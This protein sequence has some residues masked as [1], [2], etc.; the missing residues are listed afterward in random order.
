MRLVPFVVVLASGLVFAQPAPDAGTQVYSKVVRSTVWIHSRHGQAQATGSGSLIDR[1]RSLVLTNYHVVGDEDRATV[2]FPAYRDGKLVAERSEYQRRLGEIGIKGR[3][4]ARDPEHDLAVIQIDTVPAGVSAL[5]LVDK[6]VSTGQS[7]HSIGNPGGS[8]ALWVYTPGRVRQVYKKQW[9]AKLDNRIANFS[10]EVV[11]TDSATN[12]GDSG[13]PLVND[14][15]ELVG[16][17]QGGAVQASLLSTFIDISEIKKFLNRTDVRKATGFDGKS[18]DRTTALTSHD[19]GR[20]FTD[21]SLATTNA[22]AKSVYQKTGKD[23][24]IETYANIPKDK[25]EE[26]KSMKPEDRA[27][28]FKDWAHERAKAE[29]VK[30]VLLLVCRTP[31]SYHVYITDNKNFGARDKLV[32]IIRDHFTKKEFDAGLEEFVK[33]AVEVLTK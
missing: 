29:D 7:V 3:V 6:S 25:T 21:K 20:F 16:V 8:G 9:R 11:E 30:G 18:S 22:A 26:V 31:S 33:A 32:A 13:G 27:T 5:S 10:G 15:G 19:G 12:P 1:R 23:L 2:V 4:V 17:T 14:A 24:V 28:F